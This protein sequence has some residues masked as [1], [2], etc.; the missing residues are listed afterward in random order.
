MEIFFDVCTQG[1]CSSF[2]A[3]LGGEVIIPDVFYFLLCVLFLNLVV[4]C[5]LN[6]QRPC[7]SF[8]KPTLR[9]EVSIF[10]VLFFFLFVFFLN[11]V[12]MCALN[13][14]VANLVNQL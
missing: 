9:G 1:I 8:G 6:V 4:M 10:D 13:V 2:K 5:A 12:V 7:G 3:A 14:L 11:L